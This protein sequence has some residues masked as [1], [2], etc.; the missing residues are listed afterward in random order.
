MPP[1][2]RPTFST[3]QQ[4]YSPAKS[5]LPKP[6]VPSSRH[7]KT[8]S[9]AEEDSTITFEVAE[10]QVEL[11]Q[12][13]LLHQS[14]TKTSKQYLDSAYRR[15]GQKHARIRK[16]LN[17]IIAAES[18]HQKHANLEALYAWCP[19]PAFLLENLQTLARVHHDVCAMT[20]PGSRY[21][22]VL[23]TFE[24]WIAA[25]ES[26]TA[27]APDRTNLFLD[28]L[29]D[30]WREGHASVA[31]KARAMQ[32][33]LVTLPPL[34]TGMGAD[35][36]EDTAT[37]SLE[38]LMR[39]CKTLVDRTLKEMDMMDKLEKELLSREKTRIERAVMD[40]DLHAIISA[41]AGKQESWTPAW[42]IAT[43]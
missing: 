31:L 12:L 5:A 38:T 26:R 8:A 37:T 23:E 22:E 33:E 35:D 39:T 10:Q 11:L 28:A 17:S 15:L 27:T 3:F 1:P 16:E 24:A 32:R 40:A 36:A 13:S 4:H 6:P 21:A 7:T 29:P 19:D 25:G 30:R 14:S 43:R 20:D 41:A 34:P 18:E 9:I 2:S 42:Q